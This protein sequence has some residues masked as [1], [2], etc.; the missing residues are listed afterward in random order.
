[1]RTPEQK[2]KILDAFAKIGIVPVIK[3]ARLD[4]WFIYHK[5]GTTHKRSIQVDVSW[6]GNIKSFRR[7]KVDYIS[8][9][10]GDGET[11]IDMGNGEFETEFDSLLE[12]VVNEA[13]NRMNYYIESEDG[14]GNTNTLQDNR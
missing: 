7:K 4:G 11:P 13:Q 5:Y 12:M 14:N 3:K 9:W 6:N 1:M 8:D 2:Q 10:I